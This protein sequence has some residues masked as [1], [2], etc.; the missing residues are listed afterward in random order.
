[1]LLL[2]SQMGRE[3]RLGPPILAAQKRTEPVL[4]TSDTS[5]FRQKLHHADVV[6]FVAAHPVG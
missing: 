2:S 5:L 4:P 1:M 6:G 3:D